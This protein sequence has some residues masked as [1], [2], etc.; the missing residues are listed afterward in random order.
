MI[1]IRPATALHH[2]YDLTQPLSQPTRRCWREN[3]NLW[4][5]CT[6]HLEQVLSPQQY[7]TWI[8]PLQIIE[9]PLIL[10]LLAPN[11]FVL[12]WVRNNYLDTIQ[13]HLN[14]L[15]NGD[16]PTVMVEIGTKKRPGQKQPEPPQPITVT[17]S[18]DRPA[19]IESNLSPGFVFDTFV[20]G[21][22]NQIARAA[23]MQIGE[24][25]GK[26]Y[27]PL[28][29]YG[30][31]GLGKTHLMHAVG[32]MMIKRNPQARVVYLHSERFVAEM[33]KALQHNTIEQFKR[34]Y[35]SVNAL[36]IDD[37]QFFAGKERSQEEFFHTFNA[38]FE[39]QQQIILSSDRF[40]K[41]VSGLEERLKSRFGWGLTVA[42]EPPDLETRVAILQSK[43]L[44]LNAELPNEVAFF[45]G[46]R[47]RSNIRELEGAL[48]RVIAN[49]T[50]TGREINLDFAKNA[51]R[52]M[53]AAHDKQITIENIQ[54]TVAEYFQ[55]RTS[56][57]TSSKRS[58]SIARPRQI[59]MTLAKEL[60]NHSLPE[61]GNAF[62]GRDHTTVMHANRKVKELRES[63]PRISEDYSNLLRT[64]SS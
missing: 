40:P 50:F 60:T 33:V 46:K 49:A 4:Q 9:E 51:L 1:P 12:D 54:K 18:T 44:Q 41:E 15:C 30:G 6:E 14:M 16:A 26:A 36:L 43:A 47:I 55:I 5:R 32:N 11:R 35:R 56:D 2:R 34:K 25:P 22:S 27:N 21:K 58:R 61:I 17:T 3:L 23:S 57:L 39:S 31:V 59:A 45:M 53:L 48:R 29:I 8:R 13:N 64:L 62:G 24:N 52:D 28:F 10:K 7:N 63:D 37:I 42:I 38:L 20:E 19:P